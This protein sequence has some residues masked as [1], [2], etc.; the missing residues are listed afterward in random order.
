MFGL[1]AFSLS[2]QWSPFFFAF[3][4]ILGVAYWLLTG[5]YRHRFASSSPVTGKTRAYFIAGLVTIYIA[6]GSPLDL[7]GHLMFSAHMTTMSLAYLIAPPLL[8]LGTPDWMIRPVMERVFSGRARFV[9]HPIFTLLVFNGLFSFYHLPDV[10]DYVMTNYVVH[11]LFYIALYIAA[12]LMWWHMVNPLSDWKVLSDVKRLGYVFANGVLLT[13]ACALIIFAG[14]PLY[15][16]YSDAGT[17]AQAMGYCVPGM[18]AAAFL[19]AFGG[20]EYFALMDPVHDQQ[21]GG[22]IMKLVQETMYGSI[23]FYIFIRWYRRE[24][25][26][27]SLDSEDH[28]ELKMDPGSLNRA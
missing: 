6:H 13:P 16:I 1:E 27:E 28:D 2:A 21:L 5:K 3:I 17:W 19:Q 25:P 4:A 23:L 10:H 8:W 11:T 9:I 22:V 24:N 26:G 15:A 7:M 20:P 12:M 14:A 18:D